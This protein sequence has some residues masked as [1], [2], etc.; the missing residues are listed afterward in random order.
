MHGCDLRSSAYHARG[1][2]HISFESA[3]GRRTR[4]D[5]VR[6]RAIRCRV[7]YRIDVRHPPSDAFDRLVELGALDIESMADA[8]AAIMPDGV[9]PASIADALQVNDLSVSAAVGR[10]DG[11][12]WIVSPREIRA[13]GVTLVPEDRPATDGVLR[14]TDGPAFGSGLHATTALCL[15]LLQTIINQS[16]PSRV[17]DVG[18]GS[19]VLALAA[20]AQGVRGA[21][22]LDTDSQAIRVARVNAVLNGLEARLQL[23]VGTTDSVGGRWPVVVANVLPAPLTDMAPSLVQRVGHGGRLVLSGIPAS[24][25][26]DIERVYRRLGMRQLGAEVRSGWA[27]LLL[28]PSW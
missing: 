23:V 12:V 5:P 8:L 14:M 24:I 16:Q 10:D 19:G 28:I 11:S 20:L 3:R 17:L 18:T 2:E 4:L 22:G 1:H 13:G 6:P 15:E 27:A 26:P 7:P 9:A 25:A 21:T